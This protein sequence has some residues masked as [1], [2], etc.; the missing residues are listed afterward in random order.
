MS[1]L[2]TIHSGNDNR[3]TVFLQNDGGH[4][5]TSDVN[6]VITYTVHVDMS[7]GQ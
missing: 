4:I 3:K 2:R 7:L 5:Y 1:G 6:D